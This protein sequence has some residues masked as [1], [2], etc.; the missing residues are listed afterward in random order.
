MR[1]P[2]SSSVPPACWGLHFCRHGLKTQLI[3]PV[4]DVALLWE[5]GSAYHVNFEVPVGTSSEPFNQFFKAKST[6]TQ[7]LNFFF[8]SLGHIEITRAT[9]LLSPLTLSWFEIVFWSWIIFLCVTEFHITLWYYKKFRFT[10]RNFTQTL[11]KFRCPTNIR[12]VIQKNVN[13][14]LQ[15]EVFK[16]EIVH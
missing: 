16:D 9:L 3:S 13:I 7:S 1:T 14:L 5:H 6:F 10:D 11:S 12:D 15:T 4:T 8:Q 2:V